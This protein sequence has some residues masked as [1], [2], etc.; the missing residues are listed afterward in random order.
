MLSTIEGVLFEL[1]IDV[2]NGEG[3]DFPYP[4]TLDSVD[5]PMEVVDDQTAA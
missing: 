5:G 2:K 1:K 4:V 3:L